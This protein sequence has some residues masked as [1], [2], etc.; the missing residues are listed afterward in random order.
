MIKKLA[1]K[2]RV[3]LPSEACPVCGT[4][5]K[6]KRGKLSF[7]V[8]GDEI[9]VPDIT[10]LLCPRGHDPIL[11]VDDARHLRERAIDLYRDK[12]GLLT[13]D[14]IRSLRERFGVT[15]AELARLLRLGQNTLSRWEAGRNVQTAA[16]D[17]LLRVLRDVPGGLEYLRKHAA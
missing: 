13:A 4:L 10:H 8:N 17:V 7:P 2:R 11:R 16:M 15:Q 14:E 3:E 12:Y 9:R 6:E 5:M 1:R